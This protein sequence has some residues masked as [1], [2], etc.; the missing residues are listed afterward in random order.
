MPYQVTL[1]L[2]ST[3]EKVVLYVRRL[4]RDCLELGK[5][6]FHFF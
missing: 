4:L 5:V 3:L 1:T 6:I 2:A